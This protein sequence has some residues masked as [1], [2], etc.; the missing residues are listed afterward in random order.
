MLY[1][2]WETT[3]AGV[4]LCIFLL[5][6]CSAADDRVEAATEDR[7]AVTTLSGHTLDCPGEEWDYWAEGGPQ[8][9]EAIGASSA[10]EALEQQLGDL[11]RPPGEP[12]VEE[13]SPTEAVY[14]FLDDAG[15]RLGV[16]GMRLYPD[17]GWFV[18]LMEKCGGMG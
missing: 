11:D 18:V 3:V 16:V 17:R 10:Q 1:R 7:V 14:L 13:A 12:T 2:P 4:A 15:N 5:A 6:G 8:I 9:E